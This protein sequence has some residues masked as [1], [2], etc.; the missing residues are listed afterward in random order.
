MA[1]E[2]MEERDGSLFIRPSQRTTPDDDNDNHAM[3][4]FVFV[5][6]MKTTYKEALLSSVYKVLNLPQL[7]LRQLVLHKICTPEYNECG[8][9]GMFM[10]AN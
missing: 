1:I 3:I 4:K 7:P 5:M 9:F 8:F 6:M 2:A 10:F